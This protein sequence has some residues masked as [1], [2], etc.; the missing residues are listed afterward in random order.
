VPASGGSGTTTTEKQ[1]KPKDTFCQENPTSS[2]CK[3][4]SFSGSCTSGFTCDGDALQCSIAREQYARNCQMFDKALPESALYDTE[5]L[6]TGNQTTALP[7]NGSVTLSSSSFDQ[8]AVFASQGLTDIHV[9]VAGKDN[10]IELSRLNSWLEV[11]GFIGVAVTSL[12]CFRVV[13]GG[14]A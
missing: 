6:K 1:E 5:K 8:T 9:T 7:G 13:F 2:I 4:G 12:V 10:T 11:L 3:T 14:A